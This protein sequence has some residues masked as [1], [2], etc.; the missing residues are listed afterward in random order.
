[1]D[2]N[3]PEIVEALRKVGAKVVHTHQLGGGFP[4]LIV[5]ARNRMFLLEIKMPGEPLNKQQVEFIAAW[6]GEIHVAHSEIEAVEAAIG[7]IT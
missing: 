2:E 1:M 6:P 7:P 4:D 3:Q 5:W